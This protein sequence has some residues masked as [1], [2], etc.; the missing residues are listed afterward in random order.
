MYENENMTFKIKP[1]I[2]NGDLEGKTSSKNIRGSISKDKAAIPT[3]ETLPL[4]ILA[5]G[6][7]IAHPKVGAPINI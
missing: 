3:A 6:A 5:I 1:I 2:K 4:I 7:Q